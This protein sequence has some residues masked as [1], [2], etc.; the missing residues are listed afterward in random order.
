[1]YFNGFTWAQATVAMSIFVKE[2]HESSHN[3]FALV[4]VWTRNFIGARAYTASY[5]KSGVLYEVPVEEIYLA[6]EKAHPYLDAHIATLHEFS[7]FDC[8]YGLALHSQIIC[9]VRRIPEDKRPAEWKWWE[10][11]KS[12]CLCDTYSLDETLCL[13][14]EE[15][16]QAHAE[17]CV[18]ECELKPFRHQAVPLLR[19]LQTTHSSL[20]PPAVEGSSTV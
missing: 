3:T 2:T 8:R 12:E 17:H 13:P 5:F 1:M 16:Y 11:T 4:L 19:R 15:E 6:L 9:L 7:L 18:P 10:L 20:K 14:G